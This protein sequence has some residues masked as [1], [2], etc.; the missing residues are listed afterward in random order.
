ML[1]VVFFS[2]LND[3]RPTQHLFNDNHLPG[4]ANNNHNPNGK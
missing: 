1:A 4:T 2:D 3:K